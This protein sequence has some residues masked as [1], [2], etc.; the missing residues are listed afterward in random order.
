MEL[1]ESAFRMRREHI[2]SFLAGQ[3]DRGISKENMRRI[4][5]QLGSL[6]DVLPAA[7]PEGRMVSRESLA[8]WRSGLEGKGLTPR[9]IGLYVSTVN[10]F[11]K[12]SGHAELC[13]TQGRSLELTGEVFGRLKV[14]EPTA[15]RTADRSIRW[16]CRCSCGREITVPANLLTQGRCQSCGCLREEHL[17]ETNGYIDGTCLKNVL[18]DTVRRDNTSGYPGVYRKRD[19]WAARIQYKKKIYYLGAYNELDDAI[20]A[21]KEAEAWVRDDAEQLLALLQQ[22]SQQSA[23]S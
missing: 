2:D 21:R 15:E 3:R 12:A 17:Q 4:E 9:T 11:L 14:L 5:R 7:L 18:S 16:R 8:A 20:R 23:A 1:R 22:S 19:R 10:R 13:F 6:Y